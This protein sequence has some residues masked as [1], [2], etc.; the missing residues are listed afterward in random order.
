MEWAQWD[1][2][3]WEEPGRSRLDPCALQIR[4]T[5]LPSSTRAAEQGLGGM[6]CQPPRQTEAMRYQLNTPSRF[7][8]ETAASLSHPCI[9]LS[10][11]AT[12]LWFD[13][14]ISDSR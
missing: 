4:P 8:N 3:A 7:A 14:H 11:N 9:V 2:V 10:L 5:G 12:P 13:Y 6:G 1:P